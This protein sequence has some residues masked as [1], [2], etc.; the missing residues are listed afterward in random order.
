M[1]AG[2][3]PPPPRLL[4]TGTDYLAHRRLLPP[5]RLERVG[6]VRSFRPPRD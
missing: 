6:T 4:R 1:M 5:L 2:L 3:P